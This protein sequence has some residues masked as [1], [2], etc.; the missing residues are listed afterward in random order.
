MGTENEHRLVD[1]ERRRHAAQLGR[2]YLEGTVTRETLVE[3]LGGS[4]DPLIKALVEAVV[5]DPQ[6][7]F[8]GIS[9]KQWRRKFR[10]PVFLLLSELR[11]GE[12][13]AVPTRRVY[14]VVTGWTLAG[15]TLFILFTGACALEDALELQDA[16]RKSEAL[17]SWS[18][19]FAALETA[20]TTF[21]TWMGV[22]VLRN[23]ISLFQTRNNPYGVDR[24]SGGA[25]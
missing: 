12:S 23:S 11:K 9:E 20:V 25:G 6:R 22:L 17:L 15:W 8:A 3:E 2:R 13:G 19:L 7:G 16:L 14:P 21:G 4:E 10:E 5:H 1:G 18:V 24:T